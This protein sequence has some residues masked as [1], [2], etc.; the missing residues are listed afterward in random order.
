[1]S[2]SIP[3]FSDKSPER[4]VRAVRDLAAGRSNAT[5][6]FSLATSGTTTTVQ[7]RYC[8]ASSFIGLMPLNPAAQAA[9]AFVSAQAPGSFTVTHVASAA[10][11][12][13]RYVIRG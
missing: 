12:Q 7:A 5:G 13:F 4:I 9:G 8:G 6:N 3:T 1:M 10:A 11:R 2:L